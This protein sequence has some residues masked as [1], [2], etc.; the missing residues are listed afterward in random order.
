MEELIAAKGLT[1]HFN[2]A[3]GR[4]VALNNIDLSVSKG[5]ITGLVG[6]DGAGKTT[7]M[8]LITGLMPLTSGSLTVAGEKLD[9]TLNNAQQ[10]QSVISYLP[11]K[12]G[13]YEDLTVAENVELYAG[14]N[15]VD[16]KIFK[17]RYTRLLAMT[18]LTPFADRL[19]GNLSGGMKQK[20]G[21]ACTLIKM[22]QIL[23]LDEPSI[24]VD[25]LSR[26]E[27]WQL[28]QDLVREEN[29]TVLVSTAY[30][31]EAYLC[32]RLYVLNH[33]KI[34]GQ[35]KPTE[36]ACVLAKIFPTPDSYG[37]RVRKNNAKP[38]IVVHD[39]V[40]KFGDF[41]AVFH[42]SFEVYAGEIFG[43][44]GPN[45]AGKTTTF[46]MLCGLLPV[47]SGELSVAGVDMKNAT[48]AAK[49]KI[50]YVA[51]KFSL[52]ENLTVY[53][54]MYFF[55]GIY[56]M[57]GSELDCRIAEVLAEFSLIDKSDYAAGTLPAGYKQRLQLA[58]ALLHKPQV[59]F[60]DEPTSGIDPV[61]RLE[62]WR[63][64]QSLAQS[65]VTIIITTHFMEETEY[66]NRFMIQDGGKMLVIGTPL[67]LRTSY[68][69]PTASMND[70]F[71]KIV[72]NARR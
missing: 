62:F 18:S 19:A 17:S 68:N 35:G 16:K 15:N 47:T 1:K 50:G 39:L 60:L 12:F 31:E 59:L 27:L 63:I 43:L 14:I 42:T 53:E 52:Y 48:T 34:I 44:L 66:C 25:P 56:G 8:R 70:I 36:L 69:M 9:D 49:A 72:D 24:G 11:Q 57:Y 32:D 38:L 22:P 33:G 40:K 51:Q 65:G 30:L 2:T 37:N 10:V 28:I 67:E 45:G 3:K 58:T 4:I 41:T 61:A 64:L 54:N 5:K 20:L 13:L 7:L 29:L 46:R 55:G 26:R 6:A 71:L 21:L 23:L